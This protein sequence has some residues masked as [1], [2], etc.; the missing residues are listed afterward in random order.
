LKKNIL[1][2]N[3]EPDMTKMLRITLEREGFL[4]DVFN[5]P[6]VALEYFKPNMYDLVVLDI[7]MSKMDGFD[8]HNWLK[9]KDHNIQICFLTASTETYREEL[10]KQKHCEIDKELLWE[11]PQPTKEII[12]KIKKRVGLC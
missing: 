12:S 1:I 10:L 9:K 2:V 4:V 6:V 3:D 8:L 5:D 7:K 11:M